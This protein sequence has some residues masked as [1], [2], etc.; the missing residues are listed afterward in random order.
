[1]DPMVVD[2]RRLKAVVCRL[3]DEFASQTRS[4]A[5]RL[6]D[7][8][9]YWTIPAELKL[10]GDGQQPSTLHVGRLRDDWEMIQSIADRPMDQIMTPYSLTE[11]AP[12]LDYMGNSVIKTI[13]LA[14]GVDGS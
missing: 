13:D 14:D 8:D 10:V 11:V 9:Y 12:L 2:L 4:E 3:I 5:F 6:P 7:A 1:M